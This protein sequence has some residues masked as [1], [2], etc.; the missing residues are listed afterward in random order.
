MSPVKHEFQPEISICSGTLS[1]RFPAANKSDINKQSSPPLAS[2]LVQQSSPNEVPHT[3]IT[4]IKTKSIPEDLGEKTISSPRS[5]SI[6][7]LS[8][9]TNKEAP[10]SSKEVLNSAK[11]DSLADLVS[12]TSSQPNTETT[13]V[14]KENENQ[15]DSGHLPTDKSVHLGTPLSE[16][17]ESIS[18][19]IES[20]ASSSALSKTSN[21]DKTILKLNLNEENSYQLANA[22]SETKQSEDSVKAKDKLGDS[23]S[24]SEQYSEDFEVDKTVSSQPSQ[25]FGELE[26]DDKSKDEEMSQYSL[27][28]TISEVEQED[29]IS[30][31][32]SVHSDTS[33]RTSPSKSLILSNSPR[34][35]PDGQFDISATPLHASP[36]SLT[37]EQNVSKESTD[38]LIHSELQ[39]NMEGLSS[40]SIEPQPLIDSGDG[41]LN[42]TSKQIENVVDEILNK[43]V[44]ESVSTIC[45]IAAGKK[46]T[47]SN[48]KKAAPAV[49]PKP[50]RKT[51]PDQSQS[52]TL[53]VTVAEENNIEKYESATILTSEILTESKP[54]TEPEETK[55]DKYKR[56]K[57][58]LTNELMESLLAESIKKVLDVR[59]RKID[60]TKPVS[61]VKSPQEIIIDE[62]KITTRKSSS[63]EVPAFSLDDDPFLWSLS[64]DSESSDDFPQADSDEFDK[65]IPRPHSPLPNE[66]KV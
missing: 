51:S 52:V 57:Q 27:D 49:L 61:L 9:M 13:K 45:K 53:P 29:E 20:M 21:N 22:E 14:S 2:H 38:R 35:I 26:D 24:F 40:V 55:D 59:Q 25:S 44:S 65:N 63:F 34:G 64:P 23:T 6:S 48:V 12:R 66:P 36:V 47:M 32:F 28:K 60:N 1:P 31:Q 41:V 43:F 4:D 50:K 17:S 54:L 56:I 46:E 62:K 33:T 30:E 39:E 7:G 58:Q 8:K 5:V 18:E 3:S 15:V 10:S 11:V 37:P 19:K 42:S 16:I